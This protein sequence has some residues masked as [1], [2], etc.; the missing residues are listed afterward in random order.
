MKDIKQLV[1]S[2]VSEIEKEQTQRQ[3]ATPAKLAVDAAAA[4]AANDDSGIG[5]KGAPLSAGQLHYPLSKFETGSLKAKSGKAFAEVTYE[6]LIAGG[7][8]PDDLKTHE[9]TLRRQAEVAYGA[10]KKQFGDNLM[11]AAE[12][13]SIPDEEVLEIYNLLRPN[14]TDKQTLL[15]T[16]KR[17]REMYGADNIAALIEEAAAVYG[18]RGILK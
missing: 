16:A 13:V 5:K 2:I 6:Q 3:A 7:I 14:R 18:K 11:R 15:D 9:E 4:T 12:M 1:A 17:M 10:G 8:Q